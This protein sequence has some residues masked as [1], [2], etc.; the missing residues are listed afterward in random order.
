MG[1]HHSKLNT[2]ERDKLAHLF[3]SGISISEMARQL[4]RS[5]STIS[6]EIS[7]HKHYD[8]TLCRFVYEPIRA[9]VEASSLRALTNGQRRRKP[10]KL[11][12][13][14]RSKLE[15]GWSPE[16]ISGRFALDSKECNYTS[17]IYYAK[18][19]SA[20]CIYQYIFQPQNACDEL[21]KYLRRK[22]N[23]RRKQ[24]GRSVH[25]SNICNRVSI[26]QRPKQANDRSEFGHYEGDSVEGLRSVGDGIRTEVERKS[27]YLFALKV[28]KI[29]S[30]EAIIAQ[31]RIFSELPPE[32]RLSDTLDNGKEHHDHTI[33]NKSLHMNTYF[34]HPYCSW[35]RGTNENT[36]GLIREYFPKGTDFSKV[37]QT[38][39]DGVVNS[40]NTR[41]KKILGYRTPLEVF[42]EELRRCSDRW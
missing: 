39:L 35:E 30:N 25:K 12:I 9:Q 27:R 18:N 1:K 36:N 14:I 26:S 3:A 2:R 33:L 17:S 37:S 4:L 40:I 6:K 42:T 19:V 38:E 16:E 23:K 8:P 41:P 10:D 13:D 29:S 11:W 15:L 28:R 22:Q 5:K 24:K 21:W 32:A 31:L 20:E 34:C 7:T